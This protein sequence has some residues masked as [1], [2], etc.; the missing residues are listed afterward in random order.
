MKL[1]RHC[2]LIACKDGAG[3]IVRTI[4]HARR[5]AEVFVVSDGSTDDTAALAEAAGATVLEIENVGKPAA[6]RTGFFHWNMAERYT[7][8]VVLDD[9]TRLSP[10]FILEAA[11][12]F[13]PKGWDDDEV[14]AVSGTTL[15]DEAH[16]QRWNLWTNARAFAYWRYNWGVKVGQSAIKAITV[17]P[18]SNTMF[19]T[20][21]FA[22]LLERDVR[23]IVDD[24][25][26]ILD[27]QTEDMGKVVHRREAKAYVQDPATTREY[28]KQMLRWMWGTFQGVRGHRIGRRM[29]WFSLS[30]SFLLFDWLLYVIAWPAFLAFT[31]WW[32]YRADNLPFVV[33][34]YLGGYFIWA[35]IGAIALRRWRMPLLFWGLIVM[36]WVNRV[37][38][39]PRILQGMEVPDCGNMCLGFPDPTRIYTRKGGMT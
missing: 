19:R 11:Q 21:V 3:T 39:H 22:K 35:T 28:Y 31:G 15:N 7:H 23:Y 34:L 17:L 13:S 26:W 30:Y 16:E 27:I 18:G 5:Q 38:L 29:S 1:K 36:D 9:D 25:Q 2:I 20:D 32:A 33:A 8:I 4:E 24:T 6:L 12:G 37:H 14:V 10:N